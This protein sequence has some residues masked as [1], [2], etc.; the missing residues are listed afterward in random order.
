[1]CATVNNKLGAIRVAEPVPS[2]VKICVVAWKFCSPFGAF[3]TISL[4]FGKFAV[5][6]KSTFPTSVRAKSVFGDTESNTALMTVFPRA[7]LLT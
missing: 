1:M 4:G 5:P 2:G 6:L 3:F 7:T